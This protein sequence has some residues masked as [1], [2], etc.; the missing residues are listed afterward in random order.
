M[1]LD[2]VKLN[3]GASPIWVKEDWQILDHKLSSST[4]PAIAGDAS[5]IQLADES[6]EIV[7]CSH[8]F[9]HISKPEIALNKIKN[10][11]EW[12]LIEVPLENAIWPN[13]VSKFKRAQRN[14][15]PL[16]HVNFWSKKSFNNFLIKNN[17]ITIN[18]FQYASAP[19]SKYNNWLKRCIERAILIN[20]GTT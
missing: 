11:S 19:F 8:V 14:N 17:F 18:D 13:I 6:C 16:G 3:I 15:N 5:S 2:S 12:F 7:F 1:T 10:L 20:L 4:E 9:E